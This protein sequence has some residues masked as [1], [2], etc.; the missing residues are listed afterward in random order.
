MSSLEGLKE[1]LKNLILSLLARKHIWVFVGSID[2]TNVVDIDP[3][4]AILV[5]LF[6]SKSNDLLSIWVHWSTNGTDELIEFDDATAV[7]IEVAEE[8]LDFTLGETKHIISDGLSE[9]ILV[10]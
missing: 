9:L 6:E 1:L 7:E 4:V 2:T 10:K 3:T 8:L 5:Q